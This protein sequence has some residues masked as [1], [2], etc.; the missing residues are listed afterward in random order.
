VR[1]VAAVC[2]SSDWTWEPQAVVQYSPT[3]RLDN[4]APGADVVRH[5]LA[6]YDPERQAVIAAIES[7][8]RVVAE[9]VTIKLLN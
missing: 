9:V 8:G 2:S 1:L 6:S 7:D 5:L 4:R 3:D